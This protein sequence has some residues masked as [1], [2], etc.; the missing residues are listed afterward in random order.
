MLMSFSDFS[1]LLDALGRKTNCDIVG[2]AIF[3][4][5]SDGSEFTID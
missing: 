2:R 1:S 5:S 3:I 4:S